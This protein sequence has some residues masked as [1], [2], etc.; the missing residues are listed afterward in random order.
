SYLKLIDLAIEGIVSFTTAPLRW[1]SIFG[2]VISLLAFAYIIFIVIHTA[3]VG[4]GVGG[5]PSLMAVVLFLGGIQLLSL[6]IIGEYIGRI[7]N[8]TK[9]RPLYLVD[10]VVAG[11]P[12]AIAGSGSSAAGSAGTGQAMVE[13]PAA[14]DL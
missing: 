5:Y 8:E 1:S 12:A 13:H 14:R 2:A 7:F 6:G 3:L 11:P 9:N 4:S 10:S